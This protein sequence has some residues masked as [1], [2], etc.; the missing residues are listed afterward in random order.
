MIAGMN[1]SPSAAAAL[2]LAT[3]PTFSAVPEVLRFDLLRLAQI[4]GFARL[5]TVAFD[6][7]GFLDE[8]S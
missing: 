1:C 8:S 2:S 3:R 5:L 4:H 6:A 7:V